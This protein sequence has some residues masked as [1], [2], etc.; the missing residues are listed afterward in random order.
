MCQVYR[1]ELFSAIDSIF[2]FEGCGIGYIDQVSSRVLRV[3][4]HQTGLQT[5]VILEEE[6]APPVGRTA[7]LNAVPEKDSRLT[8]EIGVMGISRGLAV[9]TGMAVAG[10][11]AAVPFSS[12]AS[13][14][15]VVLTGAA[16]LASD[17]HFGIT[18]SKVINGLVD[19]E[20]N[21]ILLSSEWVGWAGDILD[22]I[23][24]ME[25]IASSDQAI[26]AALRVNRVSGSFEP[27]LRRMN[28]VE[29]RHLARELGRW[30]DQ[31]QLDDLV[32]QGQFPSI[33][34][35]AKITRALQRELY[36][37]VSSALNFMSSSIL[38]RVMVH[39]IQDQ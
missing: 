7:P 32:R 20:T 12:H 16:A 28:R 27:F 3:S 38:R 34:R 24:L 36:G 17:S 11:T 37:A 19:P 2:E 5:Y 4:E 21:D 18:V 6:D 8:G 23:S 10:S 14:A 9:L 35:R 25:G 26:R 39:V 30:V 15:I 22:I 31:H 33:Y 29:R 13:S 1:E